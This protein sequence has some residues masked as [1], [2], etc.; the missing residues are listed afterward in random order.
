MPR[1]MFRERERF[2]KY[3]LQVMGADGVDLKSVLE[4]KGPDTMK[5]VR[6]MLRAAAAACVAPRPRVKLPLT[7]QVSLPGGRTAGV[8]HAR[9]SEHAASF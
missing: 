6:E 3:R 7:G 4:K 9:S 1:L 5:R 2:T 8:C